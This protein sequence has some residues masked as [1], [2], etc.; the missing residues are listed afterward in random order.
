VH[1]FWT[2]WFRHL[3]DED[4][5]AEQNLSVIFGTFVHL[6]PRLP[7]QAGLPEILVERF[8]PA[9]PSNE[10]SFAYLVSRAHTDAAATG[11]QEE[12][13]AALAAAIAWSESAFES[14]LD[15]DHAGFL[16]LTVHALELH[17]ERF[18]LMVDPD[19]LL[20]A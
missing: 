7:P 3:G 5:E 2:F 8:D 20:V 1:V 13:P 16:E 6:C 12:R 4:P 10:A 14:V 17:V 19:A 15:E 9:D 11:P 18:K